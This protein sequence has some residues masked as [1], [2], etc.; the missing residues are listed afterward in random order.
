MARIIDTADIADYHDLSGSESDWV[1][2]GLDCC[3]TLEVLHELESQIDPVAQQTYDFSRAILAPVMEMSLIGMR[4]DTKQRNLMLERI[5]DEISKVEKNLDRI[6]R[7]GVGLTEFNWRSPKQLAWLLYDCFGIRAIRK[8]RQDGTFGETTG[9]DALEKLCFN[10]FAEPICSHILHLRDLDKRRQ[11]LQTPL[12]TDG[13]MRCDYN[14]AGTKTGRLS[15][16]MSIL[17]TGGNM[18]NIDRNLRSIFIADEGM[19][20]CNIDL[21]QADA[22]NVGALCWDLF[23]ETQGAERAGRYLDACESGDLHTQVCRLAWPELPWTGDYSRDR[24]IADKRFYRTFSYR[25]MAKRLGHGTN[26]LGTPPTMSAHTKVAINIINEFQLRYFA[27]FPCIQDWHDW[28]PKHISKF[29]NLTT[30]YGDRRFFWGRPYDHNVKREAVAHCPQ[31]MTAKQINMAILNLWREAKGAIVFLGQV[32]DSFMFQYPEKYESEIVEWAI[33][34][35]PVTIPLKCDR[36]FSVPCEAKVGWNWGDDDD[37][38]LEGLAK[39]GGPETRTRK[40][41]P[42][43]RTLSIFSDDA[44]QGV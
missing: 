15:S 21:E 5:K 33:A 17:G 42:E 1:Y 44:W 18:Q 24:P 27:G 34:N 4:V 28:V 6:L 38:N 40:P 37:E 13:R 36:E 12:D 11:F 43:N 20:F 9:R 2:N 23:V 41:I 3:V 35:T 14:V 31:S 29:R 7:N 30:L 26:Y 19:K 10:Y 16:Y 8:R 22:R 25:D 39:Y 32:H